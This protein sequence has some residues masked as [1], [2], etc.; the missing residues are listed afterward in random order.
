MVSVGNV[1][2]SWQCT[3]GIKT[4]SLDET[5]KSRSVDHGEQMSRDCVRVL[6]VGEALG[7]AEC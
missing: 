4:V 3:F 7:A 1:N 6:Q 2:G 5:R